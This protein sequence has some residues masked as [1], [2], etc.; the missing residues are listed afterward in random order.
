M[1]VEAMV[2]EVNPFL[3]VALFFFLRDCCSGIQ[4]NKWRTGKGGAELPAW[5]DGGNS[6]VA[7]C[8]FSV[9]IVWG[10]ST[11]QLELGWQDMVSGGERTFSP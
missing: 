8:V 6:A 9:S 11:V 3:L 2:I 7:E 10:V 5:G 4:K 1:L